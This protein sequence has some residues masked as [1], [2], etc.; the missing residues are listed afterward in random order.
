MYDFK[1]DQK[2]PLHLPVYQ[3]ET[4]NDITLVVCIIPAVDS[5]T[6]AEIRYKR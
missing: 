1:D 6:N 5:F 2:H 3:K 4:E